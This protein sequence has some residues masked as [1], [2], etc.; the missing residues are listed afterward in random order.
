MYFII[1]ASTVTENTTTINSAKLEIS[2]YL[3]SY[4]NGNWI[5]ISCVSIFETI[6]KFN[7]RFHVSIEKNR[8]K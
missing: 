7:S 3:V 8:N 1:F 4:A 5:R 6:F 2:V